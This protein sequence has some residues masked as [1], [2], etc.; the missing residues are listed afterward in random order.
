[1]ENRHFESRN[2][3]ATLM[4]Q[5]A[6]QFP[7]DI[8]STFVV[9]NELVMRCA[10]DLWCKVSCERGTENDGSAH[11]AERTH[12]PLRICH[13]LLVMAIHGPLIF[14]WFINQIRLN[15][16]KPHSTPLN[17]NRYVETLCLSEM[18]NNIRVLWEMHL[19]SFPGL[20]GAFNSKSWSNVSRI[21]HPQF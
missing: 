16:I 5:Q 13:S 8:Y 9:W 14:F 17:P 21:H 20:G 15:P 10:W 4:G 1:M 3:R 2:H 12:D 18:I 6:L 7:E 19:R 11:P